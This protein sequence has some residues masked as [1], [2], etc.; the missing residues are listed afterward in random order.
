[1]GSYLRSNLLQVQSVES[2]EV[3]AVGPPAT[4]PTEEMPGR[5]PQGRPREVHATML[6]PLVDGWEPSELVYDD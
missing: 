3:P 4:E 5:R 1:M 2:I 6:V